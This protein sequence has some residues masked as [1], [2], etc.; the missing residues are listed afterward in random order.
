M[1]HRYIANPTNN[2][3]D[4]VTFVGTNLYLKGAINCPRYNNLMDI[5]VSSQSLDGFI[6]NCKVCRKKSFSTKKFI[7]RNF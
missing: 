3:S 6:F 7:F 1:S 2:N 5:I 4:A